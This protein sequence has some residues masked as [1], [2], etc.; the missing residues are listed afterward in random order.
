MSDYW[1]TDGNHFVLLRNG[2]PEDSVEIG[3]GSSHVDAIASLKGTLIQSTGP[4]G[5]VE[6]ALE[7]AHGAGWI[8]D[9]D[10]LYDD[11]GPD[12]ASMVSDLEAAADTAT[13]WKGWEWPHDPGGRGIVVTGPG[14]VEDWDKWQRERREELTVD[15]LD[16]ED[17]DDDDIEE[18]LDD[19]AQAERDYGEEAQEAAD[20]A[21]RL[22]EECVDAALRGDYRKAL[23]LAEQAARIEHEYGDD[24]SYAPLVKAAQALADLT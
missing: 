9:P 15:D 18:S 13:D 3:I 16:D 6:S 1:Y 4:D 23:K 22:G 21:R 17:M 14:A 7:W 5:G 11:D 10:T 19:V 8:S 2:M 12:Y 20:E 24:P